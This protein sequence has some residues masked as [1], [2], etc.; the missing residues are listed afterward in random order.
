MAIFR[1]NLPIILFEIRP[2]HWNGLSILEKVIM[3]LYQ[4]HKV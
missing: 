3:E 1:K 4:F 2:V